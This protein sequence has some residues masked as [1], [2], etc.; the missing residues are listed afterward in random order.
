[1]LCSRKQ[2]PVSC[3]IDLIAAKLI[4][5]I[6]NNTNDDVTLQFIG[7]F[8]DTLQ[9]GRLNPNDFP[10]TLKKGEMIAKWSLT[11]TN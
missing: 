1:M 5:K 8:N 4:F 9:F 11:L 6:K 7:V 10:M 3:N 2:N